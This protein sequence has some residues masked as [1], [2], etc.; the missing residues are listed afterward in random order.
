M[1]SQGD[2]R[3]RDINPLCRSTVKW[4]GWKEGGGRGDSE[5]ERK[6]GEDAKGGGCRMQQRRGWGGGMSECVEFY[7]V[8]WT[9]RIMMVHAGHG[10]RS[11][12]RT[13]SAMR[14]HTAA[15]M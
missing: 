6:S 13:Y 11:A 4:G 15:H 9:R 7:S 1:D 2:I 5:G 3:H 12:Y 10:Q 14:T 8:N